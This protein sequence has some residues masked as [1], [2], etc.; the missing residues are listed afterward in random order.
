MDPAISQPTIK[1]GPY[2]V[3]LKAGE[4][5]KFGVRVRI[6]EQALQLLAALAEQSGQVVTR[7]ELRRRLW[8]DDTFVDFETGLNTAV[9]KVRE[10][11]SDSAKNPRY[12]ETIPRKGY[13]FLLPLEPANG[14]SGNGSFNQIPR[15]PNGSLPVSPASSAT[16][17]TGSGPQRASLG[18]I[19]LWVSLVTAVSLF[20]A[21]G[22]LCYRY[23]R[24]APRLTEHD[25]IV[26]ADVDN[27]TG[28]TIFDDTLKTALAVSLRQS[29]FLNVLPDSQI[30]KTLAYMTLPSSTRLRP[31]V[32][33]E[34]CQRTRSKAYI[35]GSI[36]SL[37][38]EYV[39]G[40]KAVNCGNGDT[41]A[42]EQATASS[43]EQ[44]LKALGEEASELRGELGESLASVQRF[45]VPVYQATTPSLEALKEYSLAFSYKDLPNKLPH[46]QR[47]VELDPEFAMAYRGMAGCYLSGGETS[48]GNEY[49][50]KAFQLR[51]RASESERLLIAA[52][53]Y[54]F[55]TGELP[56][57]AEALQEY[58]DFYPRNDAAYLDLAGVYN[59]EGRYQEA[60]ETTQQG[61]GVNPDS[62][63][64]HENLAVFN[65]A[66][67]NF[68]EARRNIREIPKTGDFEPHLYLYILAFFGN[69]AA[70][71]AE[72]E[73]WFASN[74]SYAHFGLSLA[75][76]TAAFHGQV[77]KAHELAQRATDSAAGIG[78]TE[79]AGIWKA[80]F[81]L[82]QTA[83][84]YSTEARRSAAA[85]SKIAPASQGVMVV[86]GLALAMAGDKAGA[87]SLAQ[88][89]GKHFPLDTQVQSLWLPSIHA[90][91]ALD[92]DEPD[93]ALDS[94]R[95]TSSMEL[96]AYPFDNESSCLYQIYLRGEAY[97]AAGQGIPAAAEFQ[98]ILDHSGIVWNCWTGALAH[99]EVGRADALQYRTLKGADAKAARVRAIAAYDDFF[100]LWKDADS[101]V[102]ILKQAKA[103]YAKLR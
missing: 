34:V 51:E 11:L 20:L 54:S 72:Q 68:D 2:V 12:V 102:P 67:Q 100:S 96:A 55:V 44:V 80:D 7:E 30:T 65:I 50:T 60:V 39:L 86:A 87:E 25:T 8:P 88:D 27:A 79:S 53:Y 101:D 94:L 36:A 62:L 37:G 31:D 70:E 99:L 69:D 83:F 13:R 32:A 66:L 21:G 84:G 71:M 16:V 41:L 28:D 76:D 57:G 85:A 3:D 29:P 22:Y 15:E 26:I 42:Q 46:F 77:V 17:E 1:F 90:Q 14:H 10:A 61:L 103:E 47:A 18:G 92:R 78:S 93:A 63:D 59:S 49:L 89:L 73:H 5:R 40:L 43:K 98:K 58:I 38:S 48:R 64:L 74:S 33:R 52:D 95:A 82:M 91:L 6:Q 35:A 45:D 24:R 9:S 75:S 4:L 23:Y 19:G 56:K 81:A 97:L